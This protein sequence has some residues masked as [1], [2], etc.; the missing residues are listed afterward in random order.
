LSYLY[1]DFYG[2]INVNRLKE[3]IKAFYAES[4][5]RINTNTEELKVEIERAMKN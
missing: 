5:R 3:D 1:K 2:V 4:F